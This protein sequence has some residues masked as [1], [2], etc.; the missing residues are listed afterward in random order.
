MREARV[1]GPAPPTHPLLAG[2]LYSISSTVQ[3]GPETKAISMSAA[4]DSGHLLHH[5]RVARRARYQLEREALAEE[6]HRADQARYGEAG[7]GGAYD[8]EAHV[9]IPR[10][11][12]QSGIAVPA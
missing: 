7:V 5:L 6:R 10:I 1:A 2:A 4:F 11:V 12:F 8:L 3:P 9:F